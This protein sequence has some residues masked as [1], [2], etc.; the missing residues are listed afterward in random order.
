MVPYL[1]DDRVVV[2]DSKTA[3]TLMN[4]GCFGDPVPGGGSELSLIEAAFLVEKG[5]LKVKRSRKGME[6]DLNFI[7]K[8]GISKNP[9]F[10]ENYLVFRNTRDRAVNI[11]ES[12]RDCLTTYPRG[13]TPLNSKAN[14]WI[15]VHREDDITTPKELWI[16]SKKRSNMRMKSIIA[17]VDSDWDISYYNVRATLEEKVEGPIGK[18]IQHGKISSLGLPH[19]G[20]L[21]EEGSFTED[22]LDDF[23]GTQLGNGLLVS[24]EEDSYLNEDIDENSDPKQRIYLDLKRRGWLVRTGFKYGANFRVYTKRSPDEHSKLLVHHVEEGQEFTWEE[25]SRPIRLAHS[26]RKKFLFAFFPVGISEPHHS[27]EGPVYLEMEW[28]RL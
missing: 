20:A 25:L 23:I 2:P 13:K 12:E 17:V 15:S 4:K 16:E 27:G 5:R 11:Q 6:A 8:R 1:K 26:V 18:S 3:S 21:I 14:A 28:I 24:P 9:R 7:L 19:G 22:H 10:I